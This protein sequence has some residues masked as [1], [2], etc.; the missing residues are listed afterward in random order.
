MLC[1]DKE[2]LTDEESAYAKAIGKLLTDAKDRFG[3]S[4]NDLAAMTGLSRAHLA[5]I[6][7]GTIDVRIADLRRIGQVLELDVGELLEAA[8]QAK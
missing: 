5:R 4:F 7:Y 8:N 2:Q 6:F 3:L 1:M